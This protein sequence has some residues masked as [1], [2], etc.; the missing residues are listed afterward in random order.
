[1]P[2]SAWVPAG[3]AFYTIDGNKAYEA[4]ITRTADMRVDV[5]FESGRLRI[6]EVRSRPGGRV[7]SEWEI[8][9][10]R[11]VP[12]T[13][14]V[15]TGAGRSAVNL[16]G[17]RGS[18]TVT[19]GAG[20][21]DVTFN[22]GPASLDRLELAAGAG[23]FS[24]AGLGNAHARTVVA[25]AGVGEMNLDF[26]GSALGT[27]EASV[28]GGVGRLALEIPRDYGV[29]LRLRT[30]L[31]RRPSLEGFTQIGEDEYADA[32][33]RGAGAKLD[34]SVTLA[35]GAFDLRRR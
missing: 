6:E 23:R 33:W 2:R 1:M 31:G 28:A 4:V 35:V 25:R 16:T 9:I 32:L 30:G 20:E 17:L 11:S 21:V 29:R 24:A 22:D 3:C 18:A 8:G 12:V 19:A 5:T 34:I 10:T 26:S 13:L 7:T 14:V 27:T 15:S